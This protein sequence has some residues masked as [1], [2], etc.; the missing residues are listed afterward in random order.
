MVR[1][2]LNLRRYTAIEVFVMRI[3]TIGLLT[4]A[5]MLI[6]CRAD[7][8]V[9]VSG[10]TPTTVVI[11]AGQELRVT[12]G[13]VGPGAYDSLPSISSSTLRFLDMTFPPGQVPGGPR[14][15]FR[16]IG[17]AS[18]TAVISFHQSFTNAFI[19]DTVVVR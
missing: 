2:Q 11:A 5:T 1:L 10:D 6:G 19:R 16:F 8:I 3:D 7:G 17:A 12:L 15:L 4:P 18:G 13:T 14:Q 9:S